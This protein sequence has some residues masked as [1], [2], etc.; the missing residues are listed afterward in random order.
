LRDNCLGKFF[1]PSSSYTGY[2][3]I[4][5]G[6]I[7]L[8]YSFTSLALVIPGIF[9]AFTYTGTLIDLKNKRVRPYTALFGIYRT[10][11]WIGSD[12]FTGFSIAKVTKKYSSVSRGSVGFSMNISEI[13]LLLINKFNKS[14]VVLN[15]YNNFDD[16]KKELSE[17]SGFFPGEKE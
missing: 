7:G 15:H 6:L 8:Y 14:N 4:A 16:A 17:L 13:R 9:M 2:V 12:Q 1:G 3:L 5:G 11:K 10:G